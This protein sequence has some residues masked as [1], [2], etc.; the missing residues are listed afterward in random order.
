MGAVMAHRSVHMRLGE[1][2]KAFKGARSG[3]NA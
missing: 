3:S 1:A 2:L